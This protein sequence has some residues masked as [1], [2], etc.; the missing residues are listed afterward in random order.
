[1]NLR[2]QSREEPFFS[3]R[4]QPLSLSRKDLIVIG[5]NRTRTQVYVYVMSIYGLEER[6]MILLFR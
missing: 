4:F 6:K 5:D 2:K 3:L 1:M